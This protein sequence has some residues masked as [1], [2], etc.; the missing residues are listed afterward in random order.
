MEIY[1]GCGYKDTVRADTTFF[2]GK[3]TTPAP[4]FSPPH[5]VS[6]VSLLCV[7]VRSSYLISSSWHDGSMLL[8]T[9]S[10]SF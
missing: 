2:S 1:G 9:L 3:I 8:G 4:F 6:Y 7:V 5:R 10:S